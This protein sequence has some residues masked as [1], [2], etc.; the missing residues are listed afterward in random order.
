[1]HTCN[2]IHSSLLPCAFLLFDHG[3]LPALAAQW[4]TPTMNNQRPQIEDQSHSPDTSQCAH[5]EDDRS[6]A[7]WHENYPFGKLLYIMAHEKGQK[8]V[9]GG[10]NGAMESLLYV[11]IVK[12][13]WC[14]TI[15]QGRK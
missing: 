5:Q 7:I 9:S 4:R 10:L 1:M 3:D 11:I 6:L 8:S 15:I 13:C 12:I 14:T 2:T